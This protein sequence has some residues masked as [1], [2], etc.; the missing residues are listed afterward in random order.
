MESGSSTADV[1]V[2]I[3]S[4]LSLDRH[5]DQKA[6]QDKLAWFTRNQ[7]YLDRVADRANPYL[8]YI[9]GEL[10]RRGMPLDLALLPIIESAY[11]P[12][13]YSPSRASGI[14]QFIP[15]TG[16]RY[17]LK[18]NWWY[19]GRRDIVAATGAAL[20]YL[21][22]LHAEFDGDWLLAVAAYNAGELNVSRA[23]TRNRSAGRKTDFWSLELPRETR[24]Y[25]PS[26]L[27]IVELVAHPGHY[28]I[29]LQ[30][31]ANQPYFARVE[32]NGQMDLASAATLAGMSMD[33]LYTLNPGFNQWAT[34][35]DGPHSLLLPVTK[36][37][38]FRRGLAAL[39]EEERIRWARHEIRSGET[40]GV[41]AERYRT[42]VEALK[43][44]NDLRSNTIHAGQSLLIPNAQQPKDHYTLSV[45]NRR[46]HGTARTASSESSRHIVARGDTLWDIGRRYG[47]SVADL[48]AWNGLTSKSVLRLGRKLELRAV[49]DEPATV[50]VTLQTATTA[51]P[52]NYTVQKGDSLW[53]ISR[54]FGVSVSQLQEWNGLHGGSQLQPGQVLVLHRSN[55][56]A[57]GA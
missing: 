2:R 41:I 44:A 16:K 30:P 19:D 43:A 54:R 39:P 24:G 11:H 3:Q 40:L 21:Q 45:D 42:S 55:L 17:G 56:A 34:D 4:R 50:H 36:A 9:V 48:C 49:R 35:P 26:L 53:Q 47:V 14:W 25:V 46:G 57:T 52:V 6:V 20:D 29:A 51:G 5:L 33:E 32:L 8:Y 15:S 28:G 22:K 31:I 12:F 13:A 38:D 18:Q 1:W 27:A 10:E 37:A 7:E 23:I